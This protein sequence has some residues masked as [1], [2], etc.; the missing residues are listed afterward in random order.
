[1]LRGET[2]IGSYVQGKGSFK[3]DEP[4]EFQGMGYIENVWVQRLLFVNILY[5]CVISPA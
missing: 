5:Q 4:M 3:K 2:A 1:V